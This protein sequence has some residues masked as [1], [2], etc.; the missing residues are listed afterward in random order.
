MI[1]RPICTP[2]SFQ[3]RSLILLSH[4]SMLQSVCS[5]DQS[6]PVALALSA[7]LGC[8]R[9][10]FHLAGHRRGS[11][12]WSKFDGDSKRACVEALKRCW[13]QYLAEKALPTS[14]CPVAGLFET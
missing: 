6:I 12:P 3:S 10:H 11:V 1:G 14:A 13:R 7:Q 9:W 8:F 5:C 2:Q 4:F